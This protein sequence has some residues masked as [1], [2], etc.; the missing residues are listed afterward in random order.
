MMEA[1]TE[2][3]I[4][5]RSMLIYPLTPVEPHVTSVKVQVRCQEVGDE[6]C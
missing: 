3:C 2:P 1:L 6:S 5:T 4:S